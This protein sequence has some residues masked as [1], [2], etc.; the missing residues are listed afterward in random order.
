M[1]VTLG[2]PHLSTAVDERMCRWPGI[3]DVAIFTDG[4]AAGRR[5]GG[6]GGFRS[7]RGAV[8]ARRVGLQDLRLASCRLNI[9]SNG[10]RGLHAAQT[11]AEP[12]T[13]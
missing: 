6:R 2:V 3:R 4:A 1:I 12:G 13:C 8:K 9:G 7:L 10:P 11:L 5:G